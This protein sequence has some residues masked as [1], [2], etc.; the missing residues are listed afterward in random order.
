MKVPRPLF[1]LAERKLQERLAGTVWEPGRLQVFPG[2]LSSD[3]VVQSMQ[4]TVFGSLPIS[5]NVWQLTATRL[6]PLPVWQLQAYTAWAVGRGASCDQLGPTPLT[7]SHRTA[8]FA[9]L[10]G[11]R[12]PGNSRKGLDHLLP[13][14]VGKEE[15]I[16]QAVGLP[17][18]FRLRE[19]PEQDVDFVL[20]AIATWQQALIGYS[21]QCRQVFRQVCTA[22]L[23][24]DDELRKIQG[25]QCSESGRW[26][27][28]CRFGVFDC[29]PAMARLAA[30]FADVAGLSYCR[31][32]GA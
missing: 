1:D 15:H 21:E 29:D 17:S 6:A 24:L 8:L 9:G 26:E 3:R 12:Y 2:L 23:P 19:W 16:K 28:A 22:L 4:R 32:T 27:K 20:H 18:P 31:G 11:Q 30:T 7:T 5:A 10:A 13:P 14:G 25:A